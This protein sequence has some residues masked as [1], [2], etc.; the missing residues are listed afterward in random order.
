MIHI[1]WY[2]YVSNDEVL[3][4]T[5]LLAASSIVSFTNEGS[6]YSVTL[7]DSLI[8]SQ[9][10]RSFRPAAKLKMVSGQHPTGGVLEVDLA[11][12]SHQICRDMG[13]PVTDALQLAE[14]RSFWRQIAVAGCYG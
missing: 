2:D 12:P 4:R 6:D 3:C 1:R 11:P 5:G 10:T 13:I 8:M 9:Q 14:N 7:P